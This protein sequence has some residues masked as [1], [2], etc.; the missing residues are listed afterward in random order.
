MT[1]LLQINRTRL[2][3]L[4]RGFQDKTNVMAVV[5]N[6][7]YNIGLELAFDAFYE[8]GVRAFATASLIDALKL[9]A[10]DPDVYIFLINP[11]TDFQ[12]IKEHRIAISLPS[13]SFYEQYRGELEGIEVHLVYKNLLRRFGFSSA[14]DMMRVLDDPAVNVTGIWTHFAFATDFPDTDYEREKSNWLSLL[15]ELEPYLENLPFIHAQNS[16]S[17]MRDGAFPTPHTH[18]RVGAILYGA[19]PFFL[20]LPPAAL[21][22][23]LTLSATVVET[24]NIKKGESAGYSA[25]FQAEADSKLAICDVGYGDGLLK[26]RGKHDVMINGTRFPI[27]VLMMSHL[28]IQVDDSVKPGDTVYIYNDDLRIDHFTEL[29]VGAV[30]EQMNALNLQSLQVEIVE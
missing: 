29:G 6:N 27:A 4:A 17:M 12:T 11:S 26:A 15:A 7:A 1:A 10:L 14:E 23:V 25:A 28:I 5:K 2:V 20:N 16:G 3:E 8:A 9:R 24:T 13:L 21:P 18:I 19:R 22:N 30:A